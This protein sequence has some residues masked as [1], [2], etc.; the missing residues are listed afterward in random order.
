METAQFHALHL[1]TVMTELLPEW[2]PEPIFEILYQRWNSPERVERCAPRSF[3]SG[4]APMQFYTD[5]CDVCS[6]GLMQD[7]VSA[8]LKDGLCK[9]GQCLD[10]HCR[11]LTD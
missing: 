6:I 1:L 7:S 9:R 8:S 10:L 4:P 11:I 2:L 3:T 5:E